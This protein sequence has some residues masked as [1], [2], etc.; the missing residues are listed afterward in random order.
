M[1]KAKPKD[2]TNKKKYTDSSARELVK[3]NIINSYF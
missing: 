1:P 3:K 2:G